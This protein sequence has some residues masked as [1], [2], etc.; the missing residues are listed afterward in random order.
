[1]GMIHLKGKE[2][3]NGPVAGI[4]FYNG[5]DNGMQTY[6][7]RV[8]V[9][10]VSGKTILYSN[11][12]LPENTK[13]NELSVTLDQG[14]VLSRERIHQ[15]EKEKRKQLEVTPGKF[16]KVIKGRK[17]PIGTISKCFWTGSTRFGDSVGLIVNGKKVFTSKNN[18][19]VSKDPISDILKGILNED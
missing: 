12:K 4:Y 7:P 5:W 11:I 6:Y 15:E 9:V 8:D 1:M 17:I 19:V 14:Q 18:V 13:E 3:Y 2:I 10:Y 16:L